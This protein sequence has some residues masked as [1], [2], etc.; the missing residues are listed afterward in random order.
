MSK[1]A[2]LSRLIEENA[3]LEVKQNLQ[4]FFKTG[5]RQHGEGDIFVGLKKPQS[6]AITKQ[7]KD[8]SL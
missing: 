6:R 7:F 4:R 1:L 2:K 5:L 8:I 3:N